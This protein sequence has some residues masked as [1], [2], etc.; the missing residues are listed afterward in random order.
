MTMAAALYTG[1]P[2]PKGETFLPEHLRW[3]VDHPPVPGS[4]GSSAWGS[5]YRSGLVSII[6]FIHIASDSEIAHRAHNR[7]LS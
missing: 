1:R 3:V 2:P 5:D 6:N 7:L 4:D